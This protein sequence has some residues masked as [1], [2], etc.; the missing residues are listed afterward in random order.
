MYSMQKSRETQSHL[1]SCPVLLGKNEILTYIPQ[2]SELYSEK[3]A[4][5]VYVSRIIRE[6]LKIRNTYA[7]P[8]SAHV[9]SD[10]LV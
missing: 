10:Y 6:N 5:K 9:N 7:V 3:L 2:Y 8:S 1:L 4:E